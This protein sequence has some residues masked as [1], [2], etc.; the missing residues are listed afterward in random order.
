MDTP[1]YGFSNHPVAAEGII[2]LPVAIGTPPA[3]ANFMLDFVVVKVPS[4]YNAI[5]GRPALN[6][7]QAVVSTY[8]LKMKFPTEHGIGGERRPN[9]SSS[10]LQALIIEDLREDT[11]MQRGE[12]V[13]DLTSIEVYPGEENKTVRIGSN[14]KEDTKLELKSFE[15]LKTHLSSPPL[16][17]KPFPG[18]D[19]L[20]YLSVTEVAVSTVLIRE[21]DGVQKPIYYVSKVLQDVETRYPKIDK[22]AL[23]LIISARRL[24]PYFQSHTIVV[25][26][27]QP[28]R[29]VL[30]SPEAS[31]RL[32]NWSVELGEFDLQYK[33]RTIVKAQALADFIVECTLPEDPPQL[34]ISEVTDP[35]NLYVDGSSAVGNSGAGIILISLEGFTIEYALRFRDMRSTSWGTDVGTEDLKARI[36]LAYDAERRHRI[37]PKVR[38]MPKVCTTLS[39]TGRPINFNC[40]PHPLCCMGNGSTRTFSHGVGATTFVIV[41]IDY[42]TKCTEAESLATITS[43]KCEDFFWKNIICRFGV[44]RALVVDNGKQFDNINFR[45]FCSNLSI[46]LR[47]TSVAHPQSNG[48]TENMNRG[49][50]QGLKK[51]LNEAKGTW[52]D[53]LPKVLWAYR[54]TPH[55]VTGETPFSLCYGTEAMLPVEIGVPT[56]QALH[57]SILINDVGLRANLD[58]IE[59]ARTQAHVRSVIVKQRVARYYNQKVDPS[60]LTREI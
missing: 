38:P 42:F 20:I 60:N 25:L 57:F 55:S 7:L 43:A 15:E 59:E 9:Y 40:F 32:V 22:I 33:P 19:L 30:M 29:K 21:E 26:T 24:R 4:A 6:R 39:Y 36:L 41:A 56:I 37:H 3:Q 17:S 31:G 47:F 53:E 46:D 35:W 54:T 1:L 28:L 5:L 8:H 34:V 23:A 51:K 45:T 10:V 14:L 52:V 49:I 12:P 2:T 27:D 13:E 58:L 16:L 50:L 18:E 48:Q 44:P 11:K